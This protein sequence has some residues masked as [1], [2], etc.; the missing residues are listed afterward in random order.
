MSGHLFSPFELGGMR[1]KNRLTMTPLFLGYAGPEGVVTPPLL[2]HYRLMAKSGV[3]LV[4]VENASIDHPTASGSTL[5]LRA[6]TDSCIEGLTRLAAAIKEEGAFASLQLNHAGRFARVAPEPV[7]PSAVAA[8]GRVPRALEIHEMHHIARQFA[9]AA[10]RVKRAGFDMVELHGGTGYLLAEFISPRTNRRED[11]YGGS[12]ENRCRFPLEVIAALKE[13]VGGFPV[14][15]RFLAEEWLPDGLGIEE[16][17]LAAR[18]LAGAGVAYLSVMGGT[19]ESF[20][21]PEVIGRSERAGFMV[22][23][24]ASVKSVVDVPVIAAGRIDSGEL[25][26]RI[27]AG[28]QADLIGLGRMLWADPEWPSKVREG[29]EAEIISCECADACAKSV[30]KDKPALCPQWP[31]EKRESWRSRVAPL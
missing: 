11:A 18:A 6:D 7:A 9:E 31:A 21:L 13:A 1:L 20:G 24:A 2:D 28:G 19:Y 5:E 30:G 3:A 12:L 16:S 22:D 25:A 26:E 4:V 27:V 23:L 17:R 8:F 14:G 15:Y 29:R 10:Q